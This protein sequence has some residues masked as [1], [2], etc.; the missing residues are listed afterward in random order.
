MGRLPFTSLALLLLCCALLQ[1]Q[2]DPGK[3]D[4]CW[5]FFRYDSSF[6]IGAHQLNHPE[7]AARHYP[8]SLQQIYT[9]SIPGFSA[10][11]RNPN[12]P[13]LRWI[14]DETHPWG[15]FWT[16]EID[17]VPDLTNYG[18]DHF[19]S[20]YS[21]LERLNLIANLEQG[22]KISLN[23]SRTASIYYNATVRENYYVTPETFAPY[24]LDDNVFNDTSRDS[25]TTLSEWRRTTYEGLSGGFHWTKLVPSSSDTVKLGGRPDWI[26]GGFAT[27][28]TGLYGRAGLP[29]RTKWMSVGVALRTDLDAL[30]DAT[31]HVG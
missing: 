2:V 29:D 31:V 11:L 27:G 16:I 18:E 8:M 30:I 15:G 21:E 7:Y 28:D 4:S 19:D 17:G 23:P 10:R 1:A 24:L 20:V 5:K 3:C 13:T 6:V 9:Q 22:I 25:T 14:R 12:P 26:G